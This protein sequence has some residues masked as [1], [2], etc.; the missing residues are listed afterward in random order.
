M[1]GFVDVLER[2]EPVGFVQHRGSAAARSGGRGGVAGGELLLG[3]AE[4]TGLRMWAPV[5]VGPGPDY[6]VRDHHRVHLVVVVLLVRRHV[7]TPPKKQ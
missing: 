3:G 4:D 5:L 6:I 2:A 7:C 1:G